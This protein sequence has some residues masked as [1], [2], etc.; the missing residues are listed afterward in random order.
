MDPAYVSALAALAGSAI[1]GFTSLAASWLTHHV[2]FSAQER[3]ASRA[4]RE[5]LYKDFIE[6]ASRRYADAYVHETSDV[7]NLVTLYAL[8]S[9]MRVLS[10]RAVVASADHVVRTIIETYLA[11]NK[12]FR[13]VTE[14]VDKD[15]LNPL[16]EFSDACRQDL[17]GGDPL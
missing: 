7:S 10:S 1:G 11:P 4:R 16:R 12:T 9:R 2:Q 17:R 3:S 8:V 5:E 15:S 14:I 6:E 13:D